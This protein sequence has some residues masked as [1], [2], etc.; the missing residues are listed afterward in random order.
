[1]YK[2][3]YYFALSALGLV[4]INHGSGHASS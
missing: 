1:M 4:L 2:V 3:F